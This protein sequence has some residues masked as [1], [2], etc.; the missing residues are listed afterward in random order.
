MRIAG[1]IISILFFNLVD[2]IHA[3]ETQNGDSPFRFSGSIDFSTGAVV[4]GKYRATSGTSKETNQYPYTVHRQWFGNPLARLNLDAKP[5]E[6]MEISLGFEGNIFLST[7]DPAYLTTTSANG[8]LP[9]IPQLMAW[10]LHQAQGKFSFL[11]DRP[12]SL[13]LAVGLMPYKYNPEVRNLGEFMFRSGTYPLYLT[14]EFNFPMAR[15]SGIRLGAKYANDFINVKFDQFLLTERQ[16]PPLNDISLASILGVGIGDIIDIGAGVNLARILPVNPE[17]TN[18]KMAFYIEDP[19]SF[20][21][22]END[23][24]GF[25]TIY[26]SS[27]YSFQGIKLM[28]RATID[29]F[30]KIRGRDEGSFLND[31]LGEHGGK[32]YGEV[33]VSGLKNYPA[34]TKPKQ[35]NGNSAI[36]QFG[37]NDI[38]ERMPYM[39]GITI[40]F[41]KILDVLSFEIEKFPAPYPNDYYQAHYNAVLPIPTWVPEFHQPYQVTTTLDT[42]PFKNPYDSTLYAE[43]AKKYFYWSLYAKKQ[44]STN[45]ALLGQISRDHMRW[46]CNLGNSPNYDTEEIL[47]KHGQWAWRLGILYTF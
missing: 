35:L 14:T 29:P 40:P 25:D 32:I 42:I 16:N 26:D 2:Q 18:P 12:L 34:N 1:V 17:L 15:L 7:F 45:F 28:G 4:E 33:L 10:R 3:S 30:G 24:G 5:T 19:S 47:A 20:R 44:L 39:V 27:Y 11:Q 23:Y 37:Y 21:V 36:N 38:F 46:K 9:I 6:P 41:W 13:D 43:N 31:F 8:G 22:M